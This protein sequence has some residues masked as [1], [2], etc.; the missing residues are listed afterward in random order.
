M[1]DSESY[2]KKESAAESQTLAHLVILS[3]VLGVTN[4]SCPVCLKCDSRAANSK[5]FGYDKT[6]PQ[7]TNEITDH[8]KFLCD[9]DIFAY[10]MKSRNWAKRRPSNAGLSSHKTFL[11]SLLVTGS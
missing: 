10:H 9:E 3:M 2:Y 1:A 4:Y 6:Y 11:C 8:M 7:V 5:M